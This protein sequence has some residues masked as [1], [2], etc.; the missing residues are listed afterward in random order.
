MAAATV[1]V[2]SLRVSAIAL[3]VRRRKRDLGA[4]DHHIGIPESVAS[5]AQL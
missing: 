2:I 5:N 4:F 1:A 3:R